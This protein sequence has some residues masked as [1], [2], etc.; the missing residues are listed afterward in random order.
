MHRNQADLHD[1]ERPARE[2]CLPIT[3]LSVG[4]ENRLVTATKIAAIAGAYRANA[5]PR[6]HRHADEHQG[7]CEPDVHR[8]P[9]AEQ[10]HAPAD[11]GRDRDVDLCEEG[12]P[13][14][15]NDR[16]ISR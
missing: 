2:P 10:Q 7:Q 1:D 13:S 15:P 14:R 3:L 6:D 5:L 8:M 4:F 12:R 11:A 16:T 9:L